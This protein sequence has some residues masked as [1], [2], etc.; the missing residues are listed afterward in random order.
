MAWQLMQRALPLKSTQPCRAFSEIA[1][2]LPARNRSKG[3]LRKRS[4]RS[5]AAI[6][7]PMSS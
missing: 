4:V 3:E 1:F 7:R 5:K 2:S 6:A